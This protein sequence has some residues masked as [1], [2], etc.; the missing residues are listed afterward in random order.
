M[1]HSM[2]KAIDLLFD[3]NTRDGCP[4]NSLLAYLAGIHSL[5]SVYGHTDEGHFFRTLLREYRPTPTQ[6]YILLMLATPPPVVKFD[7]NVHKNL[8][9]WSSLL[10][11]IV[12][13]SAIATAAFVAVSDP[14]VR[15]PRLRHPLHW[16]MTHTKPE[17][18]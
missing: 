14:G 1:F 4:A 12:L 15:T 6:G 10:R 3:I 11:Q 9:A 5:L 16:K 2:L 18:I 8:D 7:I 13:D 17:H